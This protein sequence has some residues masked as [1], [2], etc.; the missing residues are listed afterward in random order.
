MYLYE[1][2][3]ISNLSQRQF[4]CMNSKTIH[5]KVS[6]PLSANSSFASPESN[7]QTSQ[8]QWGLKIYGEK[9]TRQACRPG[10]GEPWQEVRVRAMGSSGGGMWS[11]AMAALQHD[12]SIQQDSWLTTDICFK[13]LSLLYPATKMLTLGNSNHHL[14]NRS[15]H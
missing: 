11:R 9:L 15:Q 13:P 2:W 12:H 6:F 7:W 14:W 1:K 10:S 4:Y 3:D 5:E 8:V